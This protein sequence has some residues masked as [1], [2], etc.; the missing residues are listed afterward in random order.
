MDDVSTAP[1]LRTILE[2]NGWLLAR[3]QDGRL[4][5]QEGQLYFDFASC[6][7]QPI[8]QPEPPTT[9]A[10]DWFEHGYQEEQAGRLNEAA[11]AYQQ[12]LLIGGPDA[13]VCFNLAT[14]LC[15]LDRKEP[16]A[17]RFRQAVELDP[18]FAEA[19]NGLGV[20]LEQ[21]GRP[22]ESVAAYRAALQVCPGYAD[23]HYNLADLLE[24]L[25]RQR[26]ARRHWQAY[27]SQDAASKWAAYAKRRLAK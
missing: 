4:A 19:W 21:L 11:R 7:V 8:A 22:Q 10:Q 2:H 6:R 26:D 27:L 3:R 18:R 15:A 14:V 20:V 5:D 13:D 1:E 17:E 16:A 12:A 25:G 9:T 24:S 23:A